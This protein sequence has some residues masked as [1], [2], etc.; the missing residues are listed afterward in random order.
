MNRA[1]GTGWYGQAD[2]WKNDICNRTS[3]VHDPKQRLYHGTRT[4]TN[5]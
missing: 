3:V 4:G 5:H 1:P 2:A